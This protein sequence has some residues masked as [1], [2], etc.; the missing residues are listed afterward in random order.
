VVRP[1]LRTP[2]REIEAYCA[3]HGLRP[4]HDVTNEDPTYLRNRVRHELLPLLEGYSPAFRE[5]LT[6]LAQQARE[7]AEVLDGLAGQLLPEAESRPP[8]WPWMRPRDDGVPVAPLLGA[9]SALGRRAL[10]LLVRRTCGDAAELD[11]AL[12]ARLWCLLQVSAGAVDL[13]GCP[14]H[15]VRRG[16]ELALRRAESAPELEPLTLGPHGRWDLPG[17]SSELDIEEVPPPA[18]PR[19]PPGE[20]LLD[21]GAV[22]APLRVRPPGRGDRFHPL[23]APGSRLLSDLFI[24]RKIGREHRAGWPLIEDAEGILWV[25][26]L[27]VAHRARV[28]ERTLRCLFLRIR[29]RLRSPSA[30]GG[31]VL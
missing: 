20:A 23:N 29:P 19:R 17:W 6:R 22:R 16:G 2:R 31:S 21:A 7:E 15:A 3:E 30:A 25:P 27:A 10:R 4:L 14:Y 28:T 18:D 5:N 24:D 13:P 26:G 1:L 12:L 8:P 11:A 9:G